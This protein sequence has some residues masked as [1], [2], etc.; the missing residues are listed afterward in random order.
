MLSVNRWITLS[1]AFFLW[2]FTANKIAL[3][4]LTFM[5][6]SFSFSVQWRAVCRISDFTPHP[7]SDASVN[8]VRVGYVVSSFAFELVGH[9]ICLLLPS[10]M[11]FPV[12]LGLIVDKGSPIVVILSG[13]YELNPFEETEHVGERSPP[14]E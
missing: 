5:E 4:S 7:V 2:S 14:L 12:W 13:G 3:S 11:S 6:S 1:F 9:S 10:T 8:I